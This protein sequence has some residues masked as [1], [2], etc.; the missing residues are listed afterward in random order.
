MTPV[1]VLIAD[2]Q[3]L[4]RTGFRMILGEEPSLSVIGEASDG[5]EAVEMALGLK[6]DVVLMDIRMPGIDGIEATRRILEKALDPPVR[7]LVLT[8]FDLNEYVYD[9]LRAGASGFLLK[10]VPAEQLIAGVH[11]VASGEALLAP[12]VTRRLIEEFARRAPA[13]EPP[14][15]FGELTA[16]E[17]EVF[18]LVARGMSN[19]EI[20]ESLVVSEATVKTHVARVLMKLHLRDRIQAVV[21]AYETGII[22]PG[23]GAPAGG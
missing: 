2:D 12:T 8:T 19:A 14:D 3:A 6:P 5:L 21:L 9:A 7:I 1:R 4:V 23:E 16:R 13:P 11:L 18:G 17:L 22:T 10:D 20:A 15:A